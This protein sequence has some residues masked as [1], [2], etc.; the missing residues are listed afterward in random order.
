MKLEEYIEKQTSKDPNFTMTEQEKQDK[1]ATEGAKQVKK[2]KK[3]GAVVGKTTGE[4]RFD[5]DYDQGVVCSGKTNPS[6]L[7]SPN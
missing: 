4:I 1:I 3:K 2:N 7:I 6:Q 5:V